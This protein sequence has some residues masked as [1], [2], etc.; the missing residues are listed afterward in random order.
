VPIPKVEKAM[1]SAKPP[2][3][4][5]YAALAQQQ[6]ALNKQAATEQ[7]VAN[8]PNQNTP[9][10]SS[11]WAQGPD[12]QWTQNITLNPAEQA[13][14]DQQR[15]FSSQQQGFASGLLDQA[16]QALSQPMS[17]EGL[18]ELQGYDMSALRGN[19]NLSTQGLPAQGQLSTQGLPGLSD[20]NLSGMNRLDPG[21]GAVESV[22][23]AMMSRLAPQRQQGRNAEIQ[24]LKNQ[25]IPENSEAF[26]R[27]L[28][29]LDQGDTDAQQQALLGAAGEYGNI[30]NR[31]LSANNQQLQQQQAIAALRGNQRGQLFNEQGAMA[32]LANQNRGQQFGENQAV[33]DFDQR[34][35]GQQFNEQGQQ[36][37]LAGMLRQQSMAEQDRIRQS[38]M[39][40]FLRLTQGTNPTMPQM[41]SF[42]GGTG[43]PAA[44]M[45][46]AG[47]QQY[48]AAMNAYNAQQAQNA[49]LMSGLFGLGGAALG[50]PL[51][52]KAG[53]FL[54][55]LFG[56]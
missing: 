9:F 32:T 51:G 39:N 40:D 43:A 54:G 5:D 47:Q 24:R 8:R 37:Q 27:A 49:G 12:G 34:V 25:G 28:T 44:D 52:G 23:D 10:G 38:P 19:A 42:M 13:A 50:G 46:G 1:K 2:P 4:P 30:F 31:G 17:L 3:A 16:G 22:R 55:G 33:A 45:M 41:P 21:F 48:G 20:M 35:R 6:A 7:T 15:Q 14:L 29:R 36:A 18:P 26:Q 11:S 53:T 56:G